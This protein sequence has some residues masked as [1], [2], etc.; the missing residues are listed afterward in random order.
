MGNEMENVKLEFN[1]QELEI[2]GKALSQLPYYIV[3]QL[4]HKI[5]DQ[6]NKQT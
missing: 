5:Q 3:A 2:L 6:V 4:L 1:K